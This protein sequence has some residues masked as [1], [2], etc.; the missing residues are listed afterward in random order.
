MKRKLISYIV[1]IYE[2]L[3]VYSFIHLFQAVYT[4]NQKRLNHAF[5]G[6]M[7]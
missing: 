4:I 6:F 3:I 5:K 7:C 2:Q 1:R